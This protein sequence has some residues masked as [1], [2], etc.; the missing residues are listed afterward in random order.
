MHEIAGNKGRIPP[1][2]FDASTLLSLFCR[3]LE[4]A[5]RPLQETP[6]QGLNTF[7]TQFE[8]FNFSLIVP[9]SLSSSRLMLEVAP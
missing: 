9:I 3:K 2:R 8:R 6:G 7:L 1:N 5:G 4:H